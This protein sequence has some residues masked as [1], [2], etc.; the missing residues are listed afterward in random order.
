M[1]LTQLNI[2]RG[3]D[4]QKGDQTYVDNAENRSK[5]RVG[6]PWK[7][8]RQIIS[9]EY[10][11]MK[12]VRAKK[13][14]AQHNFELN[15][16]EKAEW[17]KLFTDINEIRPISGKLKYKSEKEFTPDFKREYW[18]QFR[19]K[20]GE[21]NQNIQRANRLVEELTELNKHW[22]FIDDIGSRGGV[23]EHSAA[24]KY[25][26]GKYKPLTEKLLND[27][28]NI[29]T[30]LGKINKVLQQVKDKNWNRNTSFD[31]GLQ[32]KQVLEATLAEQSRLSKL[33]PEARMYEEMHNASITGHQGD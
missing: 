20:E 7:I 32:R 21:T 6:L 17:N 26:A 15:P 5:K 23:Y 29:R 1:P 19:P 13:E 4:I 24:A 28:I 11:R 31:A 18:S 9:D 12:I 22:T 16:T 25:L 27:T 8:N 10:G 3:F 14:G 2:Y 30:K 33:T